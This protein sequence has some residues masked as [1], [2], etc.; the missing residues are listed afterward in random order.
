MYDNSLFLSS[1]GPSY[2]FGGYIHILYKSDTT[3][4]EE[5]WIQKKQKVI[6]LNGSDWISLDGGGRMNWRKHTITNV[7][8]DM[9]VVK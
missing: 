1:V 2:A 3:K 9:E 5:K 8:T 7:A 4:T 6:Q